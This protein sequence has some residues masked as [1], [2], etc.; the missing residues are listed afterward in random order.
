M[1]EVGRRNNQRESLLVVADNLLSFSVVS[2]C[3][4]SGTT[5]PGPNSRA[6]GLNSQLMESTCTLGSTLF[7][8]SSAREKEFEQ[9]ACNVPAVT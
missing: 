1:S 8:E 9:K 5:L 3:H 7:T 2:S 6:S 4:R